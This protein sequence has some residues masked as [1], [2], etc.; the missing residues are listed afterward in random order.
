MASR[1]RRTAGTGGTGA[2]PFFFFGTL[3]DADV[4]ALVIGRRP[5]PSRS[6]PAWLADHHA[7]Y[8]A[9]ENYPTLRP[10]PGATVEGLLVR[11]LSEQ[12]VARLCYYE[13]ADYLLAE[14]SVRLVTGAAQ[15]ARA[16]L[17]REPLQTAGAW[18]LAEWRAHTKARHLRVVGAFMAR[19][20]AD[21]DAESIDRRWREACGAL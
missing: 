15:R 20:E 21:A 17:D 9:G 13:G 11:D 2:L 3:C 14:L 6:E 7:L 19:F 5:D 8:V 4:L 16:F 12:E 10:Q 18:R 1:E